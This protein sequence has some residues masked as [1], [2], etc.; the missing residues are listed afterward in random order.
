MIRKLRLRIFLSIFLTVSIIYIAAIVIIL[1]QVQTIFTQNLTKETRRLVNSTSMY[2]NSVFSK[3]IEVLRS[4]KNTL[5]AISYQDYDKL[6]YQ[7]D[8]II[9]EIISET[10]QFLSIGINWEINSVKKSY[11]KTHGRYRYLYFWSDGN[12]VE[13]VDTLNVEEEALNSLYYLFKISMKD[14]VTDIYYDTYTGLKE[15]EKLMTSIGIPIIQ[16]EK[17]AGLVVADISLDRLYNIITEIKPTPEAQSFMISHNGN[18]VANSTGK[19]IN[20]PFNKILKN[21]VSKRNLLLS[22]QN[23][24]SVSFI[25]KDSLGN[26]NFIIL[27]PFY[28]GDI[29]RAWSVGTIVPLK[30]IR[31]DANKLITTA[32]IFAVIGF[33]LMVIITFLIVNSVVKPINSAIDSL[34]KIARFD[35]S[36]TYKLEKTTKDELAIMA[37]SINNLINSLSEIKTFTYEISKGNLDI[38]YQTKGKRDVLGEALLEMQRSLKI[39]KMEEEKREAEEKIQNWTI[40][41]ESKI[42]EILREYSQNLEQLSYEVVSYLVKFT[43]AAQGGLFM[44]NEEEKNIE[45]LAAYAYERR[46]YL[47]KKIPFGVGLVGRSVQEGE[48]IYI[49]DVP[50]GYSSIGSGLGDQEPRSLLIV[51]FKFNEVIYA[52]MELN[53]FG[54]FKPHIRKF[55]EK[56]GVSVASTIANLQITVRTNKLVSQLKARSQ[57]LST[58][59]EEMRQNLEEMK[60][61]QDELQRKAS[62]YENIVNALNQVSYVVVYNMERKVIDIN[63]KFLNFL[64]KTRSEMIGTEQGE[65]MV[66]KDERKKLDDLWHNLEMGRVSM[67]NQKTKIDD[68]IIWFSEAYI[69]IFDEDGIP[70]KVINIANDVTNLMEE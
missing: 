18:I 38:K 30:V 45:L 8:K 61:T 35:I 11:T 53:S 7:Q 15:D 25:Q 37:D 6:I 39:A 48:I 64:Q 36:E 27:E 1:T 14:D 70:Y 55:V 67:F 52:V 43:K 23:A 16:N 54:E 20:K 44:V 41:G 29:E 17:Y 49:T 21:E 46:K 9:K 68:K 26:K 13:N 51:P 63:A 65:Y 66:D 42:A 28:F 4:L 12:I 60:T 34:K 56:I 22:I 50:K 33:I 5:N 57:E 24:K 32:I 31:K 40:K 10:P 47:Q 2:F 3:D 62:E 19:H 69:P 59:E 58:Q